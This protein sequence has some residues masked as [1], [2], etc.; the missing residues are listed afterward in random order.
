MILTQYFQ[1]IKEKS[2]RLENLRSWDSDS[3][4]DIWNLLSKVL[5][6]EDWGLRDCQ[7]GP[8]RLRFLHS[9]LCYWRS[10][11]QDLLS[12]GHELSLAHRLDAYAAL[13]GMENANL[14]CSPG[15]SW[16]LYLHVPVSRI[17]IR[18]QVCR[19]FL[20][21]HELIPPARGSSRHGF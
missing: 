19:D 3:S 6:I 4:F 10:T 18:R 13:C 21:V 11:C 16:L 5:E 17:N 15:I 9:G 8:W 1:S 14:S 7:S 20:C 2:L 12:T